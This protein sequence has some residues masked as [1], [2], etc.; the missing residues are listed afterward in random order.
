MPEE[1]IT[2]TSTR[3]EQEV[4]KTLEDALTVIG[5]C[6]ITKKGGI[7]IN[8]KSSYTSFLSKAEPMEGTI[9]QK[10]GDQYEVTLSYSTRPTGGCWLVFLTGFG[11]IVTLAAPVVPFYTARKKLAEDIKRAF[12][13]TQ[14]DLE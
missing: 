7:T 3:P 6:S 4:M 1:S 9:R 11:L 14:Q 2:L 8:P 10:R 13:T 12:N 5:Q